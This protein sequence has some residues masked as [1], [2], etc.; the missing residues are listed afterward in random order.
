MTPAE[1]PAFEPPPDLRPADA[2]R[3]VPTA[4]A[5]AAPE[6]ALVETLA[7]GS[8]APTVVPGDEAAFHAPAAD[9]IIAD[10]VARL[11]ADEGPIHADDLATAVARE[12]GFARTGARIR[13]R[14]LATVAPDVPVTREGDAVFYWPPGADPSQPLQARAGWLNGR[15]L[16]RIASAD[17]AALAR[18]V[19]VGG[20][21]VAAVARMLAA[22]LG[23]TRPRP[24]TLQRLEAV[25]RD[26]RGTPPA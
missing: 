19:D 15:R 14:V 21:D 2:A 4:P 12:W 9:A 16:E 7:A 8:A 3:F 23:Q 5:T 11:I 26:H 18:A 6:P 20:L 10:R 17:L 13:A 1:L 25:V 24:A 22:A